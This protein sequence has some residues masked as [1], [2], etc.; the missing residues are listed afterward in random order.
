MQKK[1][2]VLF[3]LL[4]SQQRKDLVLLQLLVIL[5][6]FAELVSVL[7]IGPFM[8]L[9]SDI[10]NMNENR[11]L[12]Q[13]FHFLLITK[14]EDILFYSGVLFLIILTIA[15]IISMY[16]TIRLSLYASRIGA[17]LSIRL[18]KYYMY[19]PWIFHAKCNSSL[20]SNNVAQEAGRITGQIIRPLMV[21]NSKLVMV[22]FLGTTIF[23]YNPSVALSGIIIFTVAYFILYRIVRNSLVKNGKKVTEANLER[24]KLMNEGFSG[25]KDTLL[26]GR[27]ARFNNSFEK[28]SYNLSRA[29]GVNSALA[30]A[31][32]YAMELVAT[33]SVIFLVLYLIKTYEGDLSSILPI[34]SIY[35]LAGL[36]LLPAFQQIYLSLT[37]IRATM[38]A[39]DGL[40]GD[41]LASG[42]KKF[43]IPQNEKIKLKIKHN[44]EL[45][46]ISFRY[47]EKQ[48]IV[49]N[50]VNIIIPTNKTVGIVGASGSGK[51]TIIDII[52]GLILP[53]EGQIFAD[54]VPLKDRKLREWQNN[55]GFVPQSIFLSDTSIRENIAFGL[56]LS[57]IDEIKVNQAIKMANLEE[58]IKKLPNGL[59]TRVGERGVQ[60][61][62]GQ[63]QRVGIARA[64]YNNADCLVLDEATSALDGIT[65][66]LVM[67]AVNEFS[68]S[69]TIIIIAH[70]LSTVRCCDFIYLLD[71]GKVVDSGTYDELLK[72]SLLFQRMVNN[73]KKIN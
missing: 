8:A 69:K 65:E 67:D 7:S 47:D 19:Q 41:L 52:L 9:V 55:I 5:S 32:R 56:P 51:S 24:F 43:D 34:L 22:I 71:A 61:S 38:S 10:D 48:D 54:G 16:T 35:A 42:E 25:I 36:K 46:D 70:R 13:F 60:L 63:R 44:I 11:R 15:A 30:Q 45:K 72:R 31:P 21:M 58:L 17:E 62:G 28:V 40:K 27:Q 37:Q 66:R 26:L 50:N 6:A 18:Y 23:I 4:S 3:S 33:G 29:Q 57:D 14:P 39:F 49:I 1:L 2:R 59:D 68:G 12:V 20:L 73:S 64:L 53:D